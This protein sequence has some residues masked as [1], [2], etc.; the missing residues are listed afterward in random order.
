MS[1]WETPAG[2]A[3]GEQNAKPQGRLVIGIAAAVCRGGIAADAG[4]PA[5][6][7]DGYGVFQRRRGSEP[8]PASRRRSTHSGPATTHRTSA[9]CGRDTVSVSADGGSLFTW[10]APITSNRQGLLPNLKPGETVFGRL[11]P[12]GCAGRNGPVSQYCRAAM[13][14]CSAGAAHRPPDGRYGLQRRCLPANN[15]PAYVAAGSRLVHILLI[16][17]ITSPL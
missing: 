10:N 15:Q 6:G 16:Y 11:R 13:D 2:G 12:P 9:A 5:G 8:G 17:A 1:I 4:I 3:G 7:A 14:G